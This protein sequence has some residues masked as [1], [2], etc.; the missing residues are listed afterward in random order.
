VSGL[1]LAYGDEAANLLYH[2]LNQR[3]LR[4][5]SMIFTTNK[6][7]DAWGQVLHDEDLAVAIVDRILERGRLLRLD[8][9]SHRTKHLRLDDATADASIQPA[10]ISGINR[11]EFPEP[12]LP[13]TPPDQPSRNG[14]G[15]STSALT[16]FARAVVGVRTTPSATNISTRCGRVNKRWPPSTPSSDHSV[17]TGATC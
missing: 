10:R 14:F 6:S 13:S 3:H 9:P 15:R 2:V 5:R 7:L 1:T 17:L 16:G 4:R 8:G 12:T 11:Q